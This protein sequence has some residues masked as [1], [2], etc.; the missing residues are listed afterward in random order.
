MSVTISAVEWRIRRRLMQHAEQE[1][2]PVTPLLLGRIAKLAA[3]AAAE[4]RP[5][6]P[7]PPPPGGRKRPRR[8][9]A[10]TGVLPKTPPSQ[11]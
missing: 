5:V 10:R 9:S 11:S 2:W 3:M 1:R 7:P 8:P 6:D 4:A